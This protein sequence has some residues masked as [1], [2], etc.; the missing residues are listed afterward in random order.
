[1]F[2]LERMVSSSLMRKNPHA[3]ALGRLGGKHGGPARAR[4][5]SP[6]ERASIARQAAATR[7]HCQ[8]A[9]DSMRRVSAMFRVRQTR[10]PKLLRSSFCGP[11]LS[12][13]HLPRD[14]EEVALMILPFG[15]QAQKDLLCKMCGREAVVQVVRRWHGSFLHSKSQL[16]E[17]V[18][19]STIRRWKRETPGLELWSQTR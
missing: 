7:W 15:T 16:L 9:Q 4:R 5:L 12:R 10:L 17:W 3:V 8:G 11:G 13:L 18:S 6:R 1:M 14:L 19:R 2:V